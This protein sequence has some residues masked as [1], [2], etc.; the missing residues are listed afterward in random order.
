M[1]AS[2]TGLTSFKRPSGT[3]AAA[4]LLRPPLQSRSDSTVSRR[5]QRQ[6]QLTSSVQS[7]LVLE[8]ARE[9]NCQ[10]Q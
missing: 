4:P 6:V 2:S 10:M 5:Q 8:C 3:V 9:L 7:C 1:R